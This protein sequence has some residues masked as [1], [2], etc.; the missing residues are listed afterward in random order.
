MFGGG[1]GDILL[2]NVQCFGNETNL[3]ECV[4]SG[5]RKHNCGHSENTGVSCGNSSL[6]S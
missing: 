3:F 6:P 4:H 5:I 2:D 1:K